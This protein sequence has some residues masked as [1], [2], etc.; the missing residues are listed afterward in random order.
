MARIVVASVLLAF[1]LMAA[2]TIAGFALLALV[3]TAPTQLVLALI[4]LS[5]PTGV[6]LRRL[7]DGR[8]KWRSPLGILSLVLFALS[9]VTVMP[10]LH[11]LAHVMVRRWQRAFALFGLE[12]AGVIMYFLLASA[13]EFVPGLGIIA[14]V[15]KA[16]GVVL[17]IASYLYDVL[18]VLFRTVLFRRAMTREERRASIYRETFRNPAMSDA[19]FAD[20]RSPSVPDARRAKRLIR[21]FGGSMLPTKLL[22]ILT[23]ADGSYR[24]YVVWAL[25]DAKDDEAIATLEKLAPAARPTQQFAIARV[26]SGNPTARSIAALHRVASKTGLFVRVMATVA[27][28]KFRLSVWPLSAHLAVLCLVPALG[29]LL[30]HGTMII[31]NPA[32]SEIVSLRRPLTTEVQKARIVNF[33]VDAYPR[34]AAPQL[35][36]LFEQRR[37]RPIDPFYAALVRRLVMIH[38]QPGAPTPDSVAMDAKVRAQIVSEIVRFDSLLRRSDSAEVASGIEV[39]RAMARSSDTLLA[40]SAVQKLAQFANGDTALDERTLWKNRS[41]LRAIGAGAYTRALPTLDSLLKTRVNDKVHAKNRA[42]GLFSDMIRDQ[43]LRTARQANATVGSRTGG[44]ERKKLLETLN[45]LEMTAPEL[46][47]LKEELKDATSE[48]GCDSNTGTLCNGKAEAFKAIAEKPTS[49]DGYRDLYS[50][51]STTTQY[52][53]ATDTFELLKQRYPK[54]IWPRKILS[55]IDHESRSIKENGAF[56][57]AYD[58]M[59]ALRKMD[60]YAEL[61]RTAPEDYV[62]IES[63]FVEI[64]LGARRFDETEKV[65]TKLLADTAKPVDRL[66][67]RLFIYMAAVMKPD[68]AAAK[69]RLADLEALIR[70]LP[71]NYYN[72]WV[73]PGTLVL[74]DRSDLDPQMKQALRNLCKEGQWYPKP[75]AL[76]IIKENLAALTA[77]EGKRT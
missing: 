45:K 44:D 3:L 22:A 69:S 62:R 13:T 27:T 31:R 64:A 52:V 2:A 12:L 1:G 48:S 7:R 5:I 17:F 63:D 8:I 35:R 19:V 24:Q 38:D 61:E 26:L 59:I 16:T 57:R 21:N 37:T 15:Y 50:H 23:A 40:A 56:E 72:N 54:S 10:I 49:E 20:L 65:A 32:W 29:V 75:R 66:N 4:A 46:S 41:A 67:M 6:L 39:L 47:A 53:Q 33:L 74:I 55:E 70:P 77:L 76:E 28:L 36:E 60:A 9:A 43:I 30:Y 42:S 73:Y 34:D 51:Y 68:V 14:W 71:P 25:R 11:G 18:A 58:E